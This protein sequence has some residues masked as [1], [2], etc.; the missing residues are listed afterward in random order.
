MNLNS[1]KNIILLKLL[2]VSFNFLLLIIL[3]YFWN[4]ILGFYVSVIAFSVIYAALL[5]AGENNLNLNRKFD[6][7][8]WQSNFRFSLKNRFLFFGFILIF[9]SS[10]I[11]IFNNSFLYF[12]SVLL[13]GFSTLVYMRIRTIYWRENLPSKSIILGELFPAFIRVLAIPICIYLGFEFYWT[14]LIL[15]FSGLLLSKNIFA[16]GALDLLPF[17]LGQS[18]IKEKQEKTRNQSFVLTYL[19]S[20]FLAVKDQV[21]SIFI[22]DLPAANQ[23]MMVVYTRLLNLVTILFTPKVARINGS[24][25]KNGECSG[26]SLKKPLELFLLLTLVVIFLNFFLLA[27]S[28]YGSFEIEWNFFDGLIASLSLLSVP[29]VTLF[30]AKGFTFRVLVLSILIAVINILW[31]S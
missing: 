20:V 10:F 25:N 23:T 31:W 14:F 28:K 15:I 21:V 4:D 6:A 30:L 24:V 18:V 29:F 17:K 19:T 13:G 1:A 9:S 11:L 8:V 7:F 12:I 2:G 26:S 3:G 5:D 16:D 27:F 22:V